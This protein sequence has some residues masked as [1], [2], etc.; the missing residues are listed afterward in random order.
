MTPNLPAF[1]VPIP[2][3]LAYNRL[4]MLYIAVYEALWKRCTPVQL[5]GWGALGVCRCTGPPQ[6]S[7]RLWH[8]Y[9]TYILHYSNGFTLHNSPRPNNFTG[10]SPWLT[11]KLTHSVWY[12][13]S[14]SS[15]VLRPN[16]PYAKWRGL[17]N[18]L[19]SLVLWHSAASLG[20]RSQAKV[21]VNWLQRCKW[22]RA[23]RH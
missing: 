20:T 11:D 23:F 22:T 16:I 8:T 2:M 14:V 6:S 15:E 19:S 10:G 17:F 18:H 4:N 13:V 7:S 3:N 12:C 5:C 1:E 21:L 9:I